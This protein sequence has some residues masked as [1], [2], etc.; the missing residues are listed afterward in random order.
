MLQLI[1]ADIFGHG[2]T[3]RGQ[4]RLDRPRKPYTSPGTVIPGA[5]SPVAGEG[6]CFLL[7][8]TLMEMRTSSP[9]MV[10]PTSSGRFHTMP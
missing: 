8:S 9:R 1:G 5:Y 7:A 10:P 3:S 4:P 6:G 2:Y